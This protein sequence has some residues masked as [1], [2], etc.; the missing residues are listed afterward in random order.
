[1]QL[2]A[3]IFCDTAI[4]CD[5]IIALGERPLA[6]CDDEALALARVA[7]TEVFFAAIRQNTQFKI[8]L[9]LVLR[10]G[11]RGMLALQ[12]IDDLSR[13]GTEPRHCRPR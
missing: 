6:P 13:R 7:E 9:G 2:G 4:I 8:A 3:D 5:E 12:E 1:M 10:L 11:I